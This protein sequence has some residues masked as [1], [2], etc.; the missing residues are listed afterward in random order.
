MPRSL[1]VRRPTHRELRR[2]HEL[3]E[4]E[5]RARQRRRAEAIVLHAA[6]LEARDIAEALGAHR[7]TIATDL[8]AFDAHGLA[9][10]DGLRSGGAPC[11]L[12]T[13]ARAA[14]R[15]LAERAPTE[16]GLPYGRWS[17]AKL[18][19]YLLAHRV[20][21]AISREHLRRVLEKG[22]SASGASSASSAATTR[23]GGR[24]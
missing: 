1:T 23:S 13:T 14:I 4:G 20:V 24:S 15:A 6:G 10:L 18:R 9:C 3:L 7:N 21:R 11:R 2:L 16:V 12:T 19:S 5:L 8:H 17:L 22:G